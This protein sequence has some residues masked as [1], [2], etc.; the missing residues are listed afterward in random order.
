MNAPDPEI[1]HDNTPD[2]PSQTTHD[3]PH[4]DDVFNDDWPETHRSGVVAVIGRPNVGKST[5]INAILNQKIAIATPKPQTT[6]RQQLGIYTQPDAQIL[7]VDTPGIHE[8]HN[9]LGE[10]MAFVAEDALRD[11]DVNLWIVDASEPPSAVDRRIAQ[12]LQAKAGRTPVLLVLNKCDLLKPNADLSAHEALI[13]HNAAFR[14]SAQM[15]ARVPQLVAHVVTLLPLGPRYYPVDQ[16]S[17]LNMRFIAAEVIREQIILRTEKEVPYSVGVLVDEYKEGDERTTIYATIYVERDSQKGIIIG[18]AGQMIKAVGSG[19]RQVLMAML[20]RPVHLD[21]HVKVLKD[22][23]SDE[24]LMRRF[25]Y[26]LPDPDDK[27]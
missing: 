16:V 7:F 5:L 20:D 1:G 9:K 10:F 2:E 12:T 8:A 18:K 21:L 27:K 13:E 26:R 24:N 25:G 15:G 6:R 3:A 4:L 14:I 17:D 11:A 19:A 22:W 23:R